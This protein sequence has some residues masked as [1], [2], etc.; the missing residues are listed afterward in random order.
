MLVSLLEPLTGVP[1]LYSRPVWESQL[2]WA[3]QC[4]CPVCKGGCGIS[5]LFNSLLFPI[6][7]A[8][9]TAFWNCHLEP[10]PRCHILWQLE[11]SPPPQQALPYPASGSPALLHHPWNPSWAL[12]SSL[13]LG[14][15]ARPDAQS[16]A[17]LSSLAL[18]ELV[19]AA[20]SPWVSVC[21][22]GDR[23]GQVTR[24]SGHCF[25]KH[26]TCFPAR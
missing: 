22:P 14:M 4:F 20:V 7:R 1:V 15:F 6:S 18:P 17:F 10:L 24:R 26:L 16:F 3:L 23:V 12:S 25:L 13:G 2:L 19:H 21:W 5:T 8:N 9:P 11:R